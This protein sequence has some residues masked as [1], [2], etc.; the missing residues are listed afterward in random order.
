M[1]A[2]RRNTITRH[3]SLAVGAVA[4]VAGVLAAFADAH[5]T[6]E[7]V[8][9]ILCFAFAA[10]VTWLGASA[11]WWAL[12]AA[13]GLLTAAAANGSGALVTILGAAALVGALGIGA[14]QASNPLGRSIVAAVIVS[15]ALRLSMDEF[16]LE[17]AVVAGVAC[18]LVVFLGWRR[19]QGY[20]RRRVMWGAIALFVLALLSVGGLGIGGLQAKAS[21]NDGYHDL[22]DGLNKVNAADTAGAST[23]L[24]KAARELRSAS[25]DLDG[26]LTQA[27]RWVPAVAQNRAAGQRLLARA[28][29]AADA[30]SKALS[31]IDLDQLTIVDGSI[32]VAAL[33]LLA[34]PL[35]DLADA[36]TGLATTLDDVD[37]PWLV[38]ALQSR[39][40][41][42]HHRAD[43]VSRQATQVSDTARILPAMLGSDGTRRYLLAFTNPGEARGVSGLMGNWSELT[44]SDGRLEVTA[45]GRTAE[46]INALRDTGLKLDMPDDF[47][48]RYGGYGAGKNGAPVNGKFWSNSTMSP[49]MPSVG[50]VMAQMYEAGKGHAVDGVLIIDPAGIAAMLGATNNSV[51]VPGLDQPL[52][53]A[54]A[55]QFLLLG[56]YDVADGQRQDL[57]AAVTEQTVHQLLTSSLPNPQ[58]LLK[59]LGPVALGGHISIWSAHAEE[60]SFLAEVGVDNALPGFTGPSGSADGIAVVTNN[61]SG[62]KIESFLQRTI[63]YAPVYNARTGHVDSTLTVTLKNNA[64]TTG[65]PD[66]VIGNIVDLPVG[67]NRMLLSVYSRLGY[68][69]ATIDGK[70]VDL[71][72]EGELGWNVY[73][74]FI[75]IPAGQSVTVVITLAG[76]VQPGR[77]AL[78]Y[79]PQA[80]PLDDALSVRATT[81]SGTEIL[82]FK[83]ALDRRS[84]LTASGVSAWRE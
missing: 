77:Y 49:D 3:D 73:S 34:Q 61:A 51:T 22:L 42:A 79:R 35:S 75:D 81:P 17:S 10:F 33:E 15:V 78:I 25:D 39:L 24:A 6:G 37:S 74:K 45:S 59:Q 58:Q 26:P 65:Y 38:G 9:A 16:F 13:A 71:E 20:V 28:A 62:N 21:A 63:D 52:T 57:L 27:A 44:I 18:G 23:V 53:A 41:T 82:D 66:Y 40:E 55:E 64:P 14:W 54:T 36:V 32:D 7:S 1:H 48:A 69:N 19:R 70:E 43:T 60:E 50:S 5:P 46:L 12:T 11:P 68:T 30:A 4:V 31:V 84:V 76:T 72:A 2:S 47:I 29:D 83:G 56:Q 8:D 67:T 80:L